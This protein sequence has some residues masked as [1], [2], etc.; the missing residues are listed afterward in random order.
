MINR[1]MVDYIADIN[2]RYTEFSRDYDDVSVSEK[3]VKIIQSY[4]N[5]VN[6]MV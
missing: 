3:L 1:K 4:T 5:I 2:L 6:R